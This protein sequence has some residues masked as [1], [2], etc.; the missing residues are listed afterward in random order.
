M[1]RYLLRRTLH[2]LIALFLATVMVF[3]G[4]RAL[5][6]D[7]AIALAGEEALNPEMIEAIRQR[8]G[9]DQPP[10]V[11]YWRWIGQAVQGDFGRSIRTGLPVSALIVSRIP[12][13]IQLTMLSLLVAVT[14]GMPAGVISAVRRG[15]PADYLANGFGLA[16]L[17]IPNFVLGMAL[18]ITLT[19]DRNWFP[20]S[21]YTSFAVDPVDNLMRMVLPA[22]TLGTSMSAIIMRQMRSSMLDALTADYVRTARSKGLSEWSVIG[23]HAL[24]NSLITVTTVIGLQLAGLLSGAVITEQIF[25]IPGFGKLLLD[26]VFQ[27]DYPVLQGVVVI[28]AVAYVSIN[29][30]VDI[31]YS[32]LNPRI[33]VSGTGV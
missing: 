1:T 13:T 33:R 8:Y 29:L 16:G 24:R 25:L 3:I 7:P 10:P 31:T 22:I 23:S 9:L 26:S 14:I 2:A 6:G 15:K 5:P 19:V 28:A 30:L 32:L 21:G 27:R 17:S 18:I 12:I 20:S 11:Q 4:I